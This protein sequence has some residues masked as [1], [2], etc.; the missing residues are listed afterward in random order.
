[1]TTADSTREAARHQ[2]YSAVAAVWSQVGRQGLHVGEAH[3][4]LL[5]DSCCEHLS[6]R[7]AGRLREGQVAEIVL[8]GLV[9]FLV[10]LYTRNPAE[11]PPPPEDLFRLLDDIALDRLT[12]SPRP[13]EG[14]RRSVGA[15]DREVVASIFGDDVDPDG[16]RSA[17]R[18]LRTAGEYEAFLAVTD[19]VDQ[20]ARTGQ[21]P[22][23]QEVADRL[24]RD[25]I[26]AETVQKLLFR[27]ACRLPRKARP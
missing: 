12:G 7:F 19:F 26:D 11:G 3:Y 23:F 27:F 22:S 8:A 15:T 4:V 5:Y 18:E 9:T 24:A 17:L 14:A 1:M 20:R 6:I 10:P 21:P 2:A 16:Y 13:G 25:G